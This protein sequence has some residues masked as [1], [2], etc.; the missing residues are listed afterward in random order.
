MACYARE[1]PRACTPSELAPAMAEDAATLACEW[2]D[3]HGP[4][5]SIETIPPWRSSCRGRACG[6]WRRV[7]R[8]TSSREKNSLKVPGPLLPKRG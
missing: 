3:V 2:I 4:V 7:R 1:D 6:A 8:K 5:W